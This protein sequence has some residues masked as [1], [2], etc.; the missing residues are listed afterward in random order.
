MK[1]ILVSF[2][3]GGSKYYLQ[4]LGEYHLQLWSSN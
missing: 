3:V 2:S 1:M 4:D